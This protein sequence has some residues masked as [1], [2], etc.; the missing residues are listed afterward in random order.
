MEITVAYNAEA[1]ADQVARIVQDVNAELDACQEPA[2]LPTVALRI[3]SRLR[4]GTP[5]E[6]MVAD[7]LLVILDGEEA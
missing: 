3:I 6:R 5:I 2:A 7:E 4:Q 1:L